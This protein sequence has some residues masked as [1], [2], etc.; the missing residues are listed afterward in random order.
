MKYTS[1]Q[2]YSHVTDLIQEL[3]LDILGKYLSTAPLDVVPLLRHAQ[4]LDAGVVE[5]AVAGGDADNCQLVR[6]DGVLALK[7]LLK[8]NQA[9]I[10]IRTTIANG[11]RSCIEDLD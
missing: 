5:A 8:R 10:Y 11:N 9:V 7:Y 2:L 6:M 4:P 3:Y 1:T